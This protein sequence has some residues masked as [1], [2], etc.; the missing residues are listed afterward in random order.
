MEVVGQKLIADRVFELVL[1]GDIV[2]EMHPGQFMQ[3]KPR[4]SDLLLRRPI[5]IC[6]IDKA[7]NQCTLLYRVDGDGTADFAE[8]GAGD[9]IDV[10][11]PL[12]NGFAPQE[13]KPGE[14]AL[15]IG[16]GI[17]VPPLYQLGK[18]LVAQGST[19]TFVLGFSS[20][21]DVFYEKEMGKLGDCFVATVDGTQGVQ[22]FVTTITDALDFL[23][24]T[25]Y[26][27]GPTAMLR[28]VAER[29]A[30]QRTFLSLEERMACGVGACY[31]C[32]YQRT[33]DPTKSF[34]A[35]DEGPVFRAGE[36]VI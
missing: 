6:G 23:P 9:T 26:S 7:Q 21:K 4:R 35:C 33:D 5:S 15:L 36:V 2:T 31:A 29:F 13:T 12:G 34:K 20:A 22:G 19:V 1:Q 8:L 32:I 17:G 27:C 30:N 16:G 14:H 10:I 18:D 11:A 3:L 24:D 25:V 28:V